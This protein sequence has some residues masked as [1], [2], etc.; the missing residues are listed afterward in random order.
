MEAKYKI[1]YTTVDGE[2]GSYEVV[3]YGT[4]DSKD[5]ERLRFMLPSGERVS[6]VV[7]TYRGGLLPQFRKRRTYSWGKKDILLNMERDK[8]LVLPYKSYSEYNGWVS[9]KRELHRNSVDPASGKVS[10]DWIVSACKKRGKIYII[11]TI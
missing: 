8:L 11:R 10:Y 7:A 3:S 2:Q 9:I 5:G 6:V 4:Y 1:S